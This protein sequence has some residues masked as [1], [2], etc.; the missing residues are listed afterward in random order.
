MLDSGK[1][2]PLY[3]VG[4]GRAM[5]YADA[6]GLASFSRMRGGVVGKRRALQA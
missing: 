5:P 6:G 3:S 4:C 1:P 2:Y